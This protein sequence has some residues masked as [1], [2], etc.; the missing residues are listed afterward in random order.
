MRCADE[1]AEQDAQDGSFNDDFENEFDIELFLGF[2]FLL[3]RFV[4]YISQN[5][6]FLS[7]T[8][9]GENDAAY[10]IYLKRRNPVTA[11]IKAYRAIISHQ[12]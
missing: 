3:Q 6:S 5:L 1:D 4:F 7:K 9:S 2:F 12:E 11:A 10:I 8:Y